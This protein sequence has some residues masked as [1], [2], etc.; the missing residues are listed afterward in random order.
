MCKAYSENKYILIQNDYS[1]LQVAQLT[2][3]TDCTDEKVTWVVFMRLV[4]KS[5]CRVIRTPNSNLLN[6]LFSVKTREHNSSSSSNAHLYN[7]K[8]YK[9]LYY[10]FFFLNKGLPKK[11][12]R[13]IVGRQWFCEA[14]D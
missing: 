8:V 11:H 13:Y 10:A 6:F 1:Q 9:V 4:C 2:F 12:E 3:E 5:A 14:S 7:C